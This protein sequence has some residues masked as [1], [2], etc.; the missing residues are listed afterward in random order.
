[1]WAKV[2]NKEKT[3]VTEREKMGTREDSWGQVASF[4]NGLQRLC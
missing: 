4:E 1:M 2:D 3:G